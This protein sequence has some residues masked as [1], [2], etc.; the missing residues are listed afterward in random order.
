[1]TLVLE[2]PAEVEAR[3][4]D[5]AAARGVAVETVVAERIDSSYAN[6]Y[7]EPMAL[8]RKDA[9]TLF[10]PPTPEEIARRKAALDGLGHGLPNRRA[11]V[12][13]GP[14]DLSPEAD[15]YGYEARADEQ[16]RGELLTEQIAEP[17]PSIAQ[18]RAALEAARKEF[19]DL[20]FDMD[21]FLAEKHADTQ[22]EEERLEQ[23]GP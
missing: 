16:M 2:L 14:L 10:A 1:M 22:H 17:I 18:R 21:E 20:S 3:L 15:P 9:D 23:L 13:L 7:Q 6:T 11:E 8:P 5:E 12:G 19:A 4:Q